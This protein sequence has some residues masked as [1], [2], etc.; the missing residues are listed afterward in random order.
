MIRRRHASYRAAGLEIRGSSP[1]ITPIAERRFSKRSRGRVV[2]GAVLRPQSERAQVRIL[3]RS[4]ESF[5]TTWHRAHVAPRLAV[6]SPGTIPRGTTP[7]AELQE[8]QPDQQRSPGRSGALPAAACRA[9]VRLRRLCPA[10][11]CAARPLVWSG[12]MQRIVA[13]GH[14]AASSAGVA[15]AYTGRQQQAC[16]RP[17]ANGGAA[18]RVAG[19]RGLGQ[20]QWRRQRLLAPC[21][22]RAALGRSR[23]RCRADGRVPSGWVPQRR[24]A[25]VGCTA[26]AEHVVGSQP[27]GGGHLLRK[28]GVLLGWAAAAPVHRVPQR[29]ALFALL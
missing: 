15:E 10:G 5:W 2:Q 25:L 6:W 1:M 20:R 27:P 17:V 11:N 22:A 23:P 3:P 26:G 9:G 28:L 12:S 29:L 24:E 19:R 21:E 16:A 7:T 18:A 13:A 8:G 14:V 4:C